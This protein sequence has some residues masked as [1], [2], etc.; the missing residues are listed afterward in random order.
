MDILYVEPDNPIEIRADHGRQIHEEIRQTLALQN[1]PFFFGLIF[2]YEEILRPTFILLGRQT[3]LHPVWVRCHV[4]SLDKETNY[5]N[6]SR[7]CVPT[8]ICYLHPNQCQC[9]EDFIHYENIIII[10][11]EYTGTGKRVSTMEVD[12]VNSTNISSVY[13]LKE[14]Y[15][16]QVELYKFRHREMHGEYVF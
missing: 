2:E 12:V 3:V 7:C 1:P 15:A 10:L 8:N 11:T 16:E 5:P 6:Y 13:T 14:T 4:L 9:V